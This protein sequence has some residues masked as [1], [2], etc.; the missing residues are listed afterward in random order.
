VVINKGPRAVL[1]VFILLCAASCITVNVPIGGNDGEPVTRWYLSW[2]RPE[3]SGPFLGGALRVKE[4]GAA[5]DYSLSAM[6]LKYAEGTLSEASEDRWA[7]RIPLLLSEMLASDL[8][9]SGIFGSVFSY[10][11]SPQDMLLVE[12][13]VREFGATRNT[14]GVWTAILDVDVILLGDRGNTLLLHKNY[15]LERVMNT[16]GIPEM[17]NQLNVLGE[18]WSETARGDILGVLLPRR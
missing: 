14:E 12:G 4:F 16:V 15:R 5:S 13:F 3:S 10:A 18:I 6:T 17:V 8:A 7:T 2:S 11:A 9:A 1:T